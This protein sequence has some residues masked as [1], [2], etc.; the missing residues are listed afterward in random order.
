MALLTENDG[1]GGRTI[2]QRMYDLLLQ[3]DQD[4]RTLSQQL[5]ISE[6]EVLTHLSHVALSARKQNQQIIISPSRCL[7]CGFNFKKRKRPSKP[8]RCPQCRS[9]YLELPLFRIR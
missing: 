6:K 4:V 7:K 1:A 8:S 2:R 9:T 3:D 5:R